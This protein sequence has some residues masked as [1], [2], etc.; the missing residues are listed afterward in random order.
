MRGYYSLFA[1]HYSLFP[2]GGRASRHRK[3]ATT[4][5]ARRRDRAGKR[6]YWL[7]IPAWTLVTICWCSCNVGRV[8]SAKLFSL[9][10]SPA[11]A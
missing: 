1:T 11:S 6:C 10:L 9:S 8:A 2:R 7:G 5:P 3:C 4:R